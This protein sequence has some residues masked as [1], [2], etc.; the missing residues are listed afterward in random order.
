MFANAACFMYY[1]N[2][3]LSDKLLV[4]IWD[5]GLSN[6]LLC[7][8]LCPHPDPFLAPIHSLCER[9]FSLYH[10]VFCDT[11][12]PQCLVLD[13]CYLACYSIFQ[14]KTLCHIADY[15]ELN[16]LTS[17]VYVFVCVDVIKFISHSGRAPLPQLQN[18]F[19]S[20]RFISML[21]I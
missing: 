17:V 3:Y 9:L 20:I 15:P 10:S 21:K 12:Y 4:W 5:S 18:Q 8:I 11:S 7:N 16:L 1:N 2:D 14:L 6:S 13:V 19:S